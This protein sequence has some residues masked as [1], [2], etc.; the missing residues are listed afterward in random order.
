[1][2]RPREFDKTE[3]VRKATR[4]FWAKGF[5]ATSTDSL[6][7]EMGIGRQSLYGAFGDKRRLYLQSMQSY[8][9]EV[10]AGH[11]DRL[12]TPASP[13]DGIRALLTGIAAV[14]DETRA[15]GCMGVGSVS[16]FGAGDPEL[17]RMRDAV[18]RVLFEGVIARIEQGKSAGE[19][20]TH[21]DARQ[22]TEFV[23]LTM[24]GLQVS[25]RGGADLESMHRM[26]AFAVDRLT[27]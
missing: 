11:L 16:E 12:N 19:I 4:L 14:D 17:C 23:L 7:K 1:M 15:L 9:D 6:L 13:L 18:N 25:A 20:D 3:A 5:A 22:A 2:A 10:T 21:L 24:V 26:A 27:A 8:L